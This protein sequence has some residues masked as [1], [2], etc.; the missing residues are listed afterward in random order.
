MVMMMGSRTLLS[1]HARAFGFWRGVRRWARYILPLL[2]LPLLIGGAA[3]AQDDP[4]RDPQALATRYLGFTG[5]APVPPLTP[6]YQV[7]DSAQFWVGKVGSDLPVRV[8][9]TLAAVAPNAYLWVED[10]VPAQGNLTQIALQIS[11]IISAYRRRDDYRAP[12]NL[13]GL[14]AMS[15]PTD[16]LPVPDVDNDPHLYVLYTTNLYDDR[17]AILNPTDSLP[18]AYAPYSNQHEMMYLNT[19]P[20]P[21]MTFDDPIYVSIAAR[22]IYRWIMNFNLPQQAAWLT[23]ALNWALLFSLQQTSI[24]VENL[25]AYLQAPDT[26]LMQ[27]TTVTAQAQSLGGQQMFFAY[28]TQRYGSDTFLNLFAQQGSGV[29]PLDAVLAAHQVT[30]PATGAPVTGRDA[31]ADFVMTNGIN[32]AFGDGRYVERT[33]NIP[34]GIVAVGTAL[35]SPDQLSDQSVN[36]FGVQYFRYTNSG[37]QPATFSLSFT[38]S[39]TVSRLPMPDGGDHY[40]WS[41]RG[42][43][44]NPTLTRAVDLSGVDQAALYFDAWYDLTADWN[45][46]YVSASTDGGASWTPLTA[47][48]STLADPYGA[49]YGASFTGISSTEKPRPYPIIGVTIGSDN[50]TAS[51]VTPG[52][53]ADTAGLRQG[54]QIIGINHEVWTTTPNIIGML[55]DYSPGDTLNLYVQRGS[56]QLDLPVILG[57]HPTRVIEPNPVWL[58]ETVDLTPYAGKQILLRFE[59]VSLP[60]H[61]DQGFAV[62]HLTV[63]AVG[64]SDDAEADPSGWTLNGWSVVDN[65]LPQQW[66]VQAATDGSQTKYPRVQTLI[67]ADDDASSGSWQIALDAGETLTLAVSGVNDDT[68]V[69]ASFALAFSS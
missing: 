14:G 45:Y 19:T 4:L 50:V 53:P 51:S 20:F 62:D 33:L 17:E 36:Q 39:P 42:G 66:L 32:L 55:G 12:I 27:P 23:D 11:Q 60:G 15:D 40:Y 6:I 47:T 3:Q 1:R 61:E 63:P 28:F 52:G 25:S 26:P 59:T 68:T 57:A 30:D 13:P 56:D 34:Q 37:A 69:P 46:A 64:W 58:H 16:L 54:D 21:G 5:A 10:G 29:A 43:D 18:T 41:G 22:G 24:G 38:G 31:F 65:S 9:A 7:G 48:H 8:G 35:T 2:C 49:A 67:G 44:Q